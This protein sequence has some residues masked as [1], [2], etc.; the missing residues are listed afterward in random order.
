MRNRKLAIAALITAGVALGMARD[1][2]AQQQPQLTDDEFV[3]LAVR[4]GL[5]EVRLAELAETRS[6]RPEIQDFAHQIITD[7][8]EINEKLQD[9]TEQKGI[10]RPTTL[11]QEHQDAVATLSRLE[12][13][14]FNR[15]FLRGQ[16]NDLREVVA[17]FTTEVDQAEGEDLKTFASETLTTLRK[18]LKT[19]TELAGPKIS[20]E[21]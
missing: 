9:L 15:E 12:G 10:L 3:T 6:T 13:N 21:L 20:D 14:A 2:R 17:L 16:I 5:A 4:S 7:Y 1:A 19:A 18:H 11:D 8:T